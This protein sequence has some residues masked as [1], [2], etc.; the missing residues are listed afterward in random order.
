MGGAGGAGTASGKNFKGGN[1][2]IVVEW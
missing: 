2:M 1:G